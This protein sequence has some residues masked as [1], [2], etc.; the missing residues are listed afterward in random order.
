MSWEKRRRREDRVAQG[1]ATRNPGNKERKISVPL[2]RRPRAQ[3]PQRSA[4][5]RGCYENRKNSKLKMDEK[6]CFPVQKQAEKNFDLNSAI[7]LEPA[8]LLK[9]NLYGC[10]SG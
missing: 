9:K 6:F 7:P 3:L 8:S 5:K 4:Q 2:C 10:S 1:E